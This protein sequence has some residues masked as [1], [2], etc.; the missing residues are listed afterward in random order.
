[1]KERSESQ[2][3]I[4]ADKIIVQSIKVLGGNIT[5]EPGIDVS[6]I[7]SYEV[8]YG[9]ADHANI[10]EKKFQFRLSVYIEAV[11]RENK[12]IG[13]RGE[14]HIEFIFFVANVEYYIQNIEEE[15][16]TIFF[17]PALL[18]TLLSIVYSTSRGIILSRTQGTSIDSVILP[19]VD[20]NDLLQNLQNNKQQPVNQV[21]N[22]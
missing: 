13:A 3:Q 1:M 6:K 7:D 16:K 18:H 12:Q 21:T 11:D 8:K 22:K 5:A 9:I 19:V 14:Y 17:H 10:Q 4:V 15:T 20:T 2:I